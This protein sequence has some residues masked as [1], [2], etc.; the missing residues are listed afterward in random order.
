MNMRPFIIAWPILA[1]SSTQAQAHGIDAVSAGFFF[2]L[3]IS[4]V[5]GIVCAISMPGKL[6]Q[7]FT[8]FCGSVF[9]SLGTALALGAVW[10][11]LGDNNIVFGAVISLCICAS[12][13]GATLANRLARKERIASRALAVLALIFT[14]LVAVLVCGSYEHLAIRF[15]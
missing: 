5:T 7:G 3:A 10:P 11:L 8:T 4:F 12:L 1:C 9:A 6:W 15:A 13:I 2:G 14:A